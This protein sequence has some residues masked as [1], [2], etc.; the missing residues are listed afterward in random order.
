MYPANSAMTTRINK[1][2]ALLKAE[3]L[4]AFFISHQPNI[5]Y[6]TGFNAED[7]WLLVTARHAVYITDFRYVLEASAGLKG[8]PVKLYTRSA[9]ATLVELL[10]KERISR[11]AI[12]EQHT[13]VAQLGALKKALGTSIKLTL[14]CG[15][16]EKLREIKDE[17]EISLIKGALRVHEE[18]YRYLRRLVRPGLSE[19]DVCLKLEHFVKS[20][21][22]GFSFDPIVASGPNSAYPH[23]KVTRRTFARN[24][25]VLIDWG[26]DLNGYKSDLTRMFFLGR[27]SK[28]IRTVN[29]TLVV[30]Q[31]RAALAAQPNVPIAQ[32]DYQARNYLEKHKLAK[33]FGHALGHGVGLEIHESPRLAASN[34]ALLKPGMV[35]TLEPAVY[36]PGKFG[37]RIEDMFLVT[38][39]GAR[40]LSG[41]IS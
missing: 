39:K 37:I 21:G 27:I 14:V 25:V 30:A 7:S 4:R 20:R 16:V 38:V 1:L 32:V 28:L 10:K 18:S 33:Y 31:Q 19:L 22:C 34:R 12:E 26:I 11:V 29:D 3:G 35:I 40:N 17:Q 23:A 2:R 8:I 9:Y 41:H 15:I 36:L 6:L 5:R 24:D 13:S